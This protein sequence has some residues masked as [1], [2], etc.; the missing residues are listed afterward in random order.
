MGATVIAIANQ[1]GGV[2]KTTSTVTIGHALAY[3]GY[4]VL[5]VDLDSQGHCATYLGLP[6]ESKVYDLLAMNSPPAQCIV[7]TGRPHLHLVP[8]DDRTA[9]A[10]VVL[11]GRAFREEAV[12]DVL[13]ILN[14]DYDFILIDTPPSLDLLHQAALVAAS[15]V[16]IPTATEFLAVHGVGRII[17]SIEMY[18]RRGYVTNVLGVIPTFYDGRTLESQ[19]SLEE[20]QNAFGELLYP[21]IHRAT[22]LRESPGYAKTIWEYAPNERAAQEYGSIV[23]RLLKDVTPQQ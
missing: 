12:R 14:A 6:P 10:K 20:L 18:N 17:Q 11:A 8:S 13:L 22:V 3:K 21:L 19:K 5:L 16:L 4:E 23:G 9:E 15:Y 2:G 1:K 7:S